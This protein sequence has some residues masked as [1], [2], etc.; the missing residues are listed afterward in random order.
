M[1]WD[2]RRWG[3]EVKEMGAVVG[4]AL[5]SHSKELRT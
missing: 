4:E 3:A 2:P 5:E 1:P